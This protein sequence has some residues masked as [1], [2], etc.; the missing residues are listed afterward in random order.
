MIH[1]ILFL[2]VVV[3]AGILGVVLH[4]LDRRIRIRTATHRRQLEFDVPHLARME[5]ST[6][7][8]EQTQDSVQR[9]EAQIHESVQQETARIHSAAQE[10]A[11]IHSAVMDSLSEYQRRR[12]DPH[13]HIHSTAVAAGTL[14]STVTTTA[15][16]AI[17]AQSS[18]S[19]S[20]PPNKI[21]KA[22]PPRVKPTKVSRMK[23]LRGK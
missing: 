17:R 13:R 21:K 15:D 8:L 4:L 9:L 14:S 23:I 3:G 18:S 16:N 12:T 5:N 10:V 1:V 2:C 20:Q 11:R 19:G 6:M 7:R 22:K